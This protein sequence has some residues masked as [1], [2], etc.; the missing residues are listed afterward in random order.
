[1]G[2]TR[3]YKTLAL[4]IGGTHIKASVLDAAGHM[5]APDLRVSTPSHP[6]PAAVL[7][8]IR[9][10]VEKLPP[11]DRISA[12]FPGYIAKGHVRTAP[13]LG[14]E[15]WRDFP[16]AATLTE[17]FHKPARVLNDA[18]VQGLGVIDGHGLE[19]VLT[20]GTGIGSALFKDGLL[21]PHL[22]LGQHPIRK[23]KT[24]DQYLGD[25]ALKRKGPEKWNLRLKYVISVVE[26]LVNCDTFHL[27]GGNAAAVTL[28]LPKNVRLAPNTG[29]ITGGVKLWD[30]A[31]DDFFADATSAEK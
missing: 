29:G 25:A 20:L 5:V 26:T 22:E 18:D 31:L 16:L 8:V 3:P 2:N 10:L 4:D 15:A 11:F 28:K 13:N 19:C 12:G 9:T 27:G 24:Y 30:E 14:T 6:T 17:H 23:H 7:A 1:M 21:L